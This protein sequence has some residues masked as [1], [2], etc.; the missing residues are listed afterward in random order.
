MD[1]KRFAFQI[2]LVNGTRLW[3]ANIFPKESYYGDKAESDLEKIKD[4]LDR[5]GCIDVQ[6][7]SYDQEGKQAPFQNGVIYKTDIAFIQG[8]IQQ[9]N[10]TE[11]TI[12]E[13]FSLTEAAAYWGLTDGATIRKAIERNKFREGEQRKSDSVNLV[14]YP[15]MQ[16]VFGAIPLTKWNDVPCLTVTKAFLD[17]ARVLLDGYKP[18]Y[19]EVAKRER[20]YSAPLE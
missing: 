18:L 6:S 9:Y 4:L 16:R 17:E 19:S 1:M 20:K 5:E 8:P 15:A 12:N 7:S 13:V 11:L 3:P 2:T 10:S 14:T